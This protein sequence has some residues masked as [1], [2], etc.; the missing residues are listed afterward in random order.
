MI[1]NNIVNSDHNGLMKSRGNHSSCRMTVVSNV[2]WS[3]RVVLIMRSADRLQRT[4]RRIRS[5]VRL[6]ILE[7][8]IKSG[9]QS[10]SSKMTIIIITRLSIYIYILLS[11]NMLILYV[12][13]LSDFNL[14][15]DLYTL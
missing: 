9:L 8:V 2:I 3:S 15:P 10:C 4:V 12:N 5:T 13:S 14:C 7:A 11:M 1:A 6:V